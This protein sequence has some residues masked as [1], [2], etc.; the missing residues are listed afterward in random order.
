MK[1]MSSLRAAATCV[2]PSPYRRLKRFN[3]DCE[4]LE[5]R[6]LLS[7]ATTAPDLSQITALPSIEMTPMAGPGSTALTPQQILGA[8]GINKITLSGGIKGNGAGQTIAIVDA[9]NDPNITS[10]LTAFDN[11]FGIAAPP[12]FKVDNLGE[13]DGCGLGPG[14][15]TRR[16]VGPRH[17]SG[18]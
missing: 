12:S 9:Y 7:T 16:R 10:D 14:D 5:V 6:Q 15:R 1:L 3:L 18:C 11:Q 13:D 17:R 2:L 8:Y 4:S